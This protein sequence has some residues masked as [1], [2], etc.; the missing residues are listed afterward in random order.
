[1][2]KREIEGVIWDVD[3]TMV[4][5]EP[6]HVAAWDAALAENEFHLE[7]LSE[8]VR[9]T[10]AGKKP[11]VIAGEMIEDLGLNVEPQSLLDRKTQIFWD[12]I[13][14]N[15]ESMPGL[16]ES[17]EALNK[18][19]YRQA[20]GTSM[21]REY[22]QLVLKKFGL[23]KYFEVIVVGEEVH[24]GKPDPETYLL[25]AKRLG[26]DPTLCVVVEDATS[27]ILA[28]KSAGCFC[29]A[30]KNPNAVPQ[31]LSKADAVIEN[32]QEITSALLK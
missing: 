27:G 21:T 19:G 13:A 8:Q 5:S 25:V 20:I 7:D 2:S 6:L 32:L 12:S 18:R 15:L 14:T 23:E 11:I 26:I 28:A 31:D 1:M 16:V 10:M 17:I 30:I 9:S 22:V 29:I 4:N 24:K 3:G